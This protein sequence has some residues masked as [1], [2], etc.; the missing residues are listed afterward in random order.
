MDNQNRK[1]SYRKQRLSNI[2]YKSRTPPVT[3]KY[4]S[5]KIDLKIVILKHDVIRL[6]NLLKILIRP[7][8][9]GCFS[10]MGACKNQAK[11]REIA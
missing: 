3:I 5:K 10:D 2:V 4:K 9:F 11:N 1:L 7:R 8:N 6:S